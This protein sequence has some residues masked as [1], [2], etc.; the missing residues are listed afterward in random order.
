ML[1]DRHCLTP[2]TQNVQTIYAGLQQFMHSMRGGLRVA[3]SLLYVEA[4]AGIRGLCVDTGESAETRVVA[5]RQVQGD[6]QES[7]RDHHEATRQL[8]PTRPHS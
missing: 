6:A 8:R 4:L 2:V 5:G 1:P 3:G 7:Q